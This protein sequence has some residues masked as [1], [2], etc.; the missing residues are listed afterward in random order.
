MESQFQSWT[1]L[2][3]P[4]FTPSDLELALRSQS[5]P[6]LALD[7][8]RWS[9][10]T[11]RFR[12]TPSTYLAVIDILVR[13]RRFSAAESLLHDVLSG[14]CPPDLP[15]FNFLI[16]F[17]SSRR[18]LFSTAFD[19]YKKMLTSSSSSSSSNA[20][21]PNLQTYTMLLTM[22]LRRFGKPPVSY[23]HLHAVRSLVRQMKAS[24]T[25]PDAFVLNLIIKA[26]SR[27]LEM[28]EAVRVF[29]EMGL[30][31]CEPNEYTYGYIAK[32]MCEKGR[33]KDGM[34]FFKEMR[35]KG[36]VPTSSVYMVVICSLVM[37]RRFEE[38][39][40]VLEDMLGNRMKPDLLT[41]R[42][43]L[44]GLCRDGR[45]EEAFELLE[46]LGRRRKGAMDPRMYSDLL[47]GL[48]W[49]NQPH[50]HD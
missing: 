50:D 4:G 6:D 37:E 18:H 44:E 13:S 1:S 49:L 43:L 11:P 47:D 45:G 29:R 33:V 30:Y 40:E 46:E 26:F 28:D 2:L 35:E 15:L 31:N 34:K 22:L 3:R 32:G 5:D 10:L 21:R 14:A 41:Y 19:V 25:I 12:H 20:C 7:L 27:C 9:S 23:I 24:G 42:T 39:M 17:C 38:A 48:H 36:L 16:K 8:F